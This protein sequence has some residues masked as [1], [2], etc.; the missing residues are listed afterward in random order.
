[1]GLVSELRRRNVLRMAA[2]YVVAAWLMMQVAG[3]LKRGRV[4]TNTLSA[5]DVREIERKMRSEVF[6]GLKEVRVD[7]TGRGNRGDL[8]LQGPR[9]EQSLFVELNVK[10]ST[11]DGRTVARGRVNA[12]MKR[13][14]MKE[15]KAPLGAFKVAD[16][17]EIEGCLVLTD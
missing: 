13:L 8:K 1:M 16:S 5:K 3:V 9:G 11:D 12:S 2:L 17:V 15:V 14:G 10:E 4:D 6:A 7:G